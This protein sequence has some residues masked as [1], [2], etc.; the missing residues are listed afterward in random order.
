VIQIQTWNDYGEGTVIEPTLERGYESLE[1]A[2]DKRR[3]W[4]PDFPF[5]RSDLRIPF[6][7]YKIMSDGTATQE[8]KAQVAAIY[9]LIFSGNA[10][11]M[12]HIFGD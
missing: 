5:N 6:E 11:A 1:Y 3:Q 8:Q 7:L 10:E 12:R 2:Q 4:E 9:G